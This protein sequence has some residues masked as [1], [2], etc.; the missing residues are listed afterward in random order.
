MRIALFAETYLPDINGVVT[1]VKTLKDGLEQLGHTVLVVTASPKTRSHRLENG[2]LY[3]PAASLK[4]LYGYGIAVPY[5]PRRTRFVKDFAPDIIH[6]HQEFGV[7]LSG[8]HLSKVLEVP[9]VYTLHTMYDDYLYYVAPSEFFIPAVRKVSY[10]YI[11]FLADNA[12]ALTGP[13]KKCEEYFRT[14]GVHKP[15]HV[16]PNAVELENFA[17][18]KIDRTGNAEFCKRFGIPTDKKIACFVGR[19]GKEKSIDLLL[20]YRAAAQKPDNFHLV[21]V[22]DGPEA[23]GLAALS[24]K[25]GLSDS[26]TFTGAI[27]HSELPPLFS[28]CDIYITASLSDTNSISML[29]AMAAGVPVVQRLDPI[30]ADQVKEGINGYLFDSPEELRS[31]LERFSALEPAE[32]ASF[33]D[34]VARSVREKGSTA[35]ASRVLAAYNDAVQTYTAVKNK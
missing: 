4:K 7:G 22:G 2:V 23:A 27:P 16:I 13:S 9:L 18:D 15:V 12:H 19:L 21:I 11:K 5:S 10:K 3:C 6:I 34:S 30:N 29:E 31:A 1:H 35:L 8:V 17:A 26:V 14:I 20:E 25:L 28:V 24:D 32:L 33:K